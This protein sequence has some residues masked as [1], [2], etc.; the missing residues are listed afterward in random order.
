M[1]DAFK[2]QCEAYLANQALKR[3]VNSSEWSTQKLAS[4][5]MASLMLAG[6]DGKS[7]AN[8]S[9]TLAI[10]SLLVMP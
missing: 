8:F 2:N 9:G 7:T 6:D 5:A 1:A 10:A 4:Q 3:S